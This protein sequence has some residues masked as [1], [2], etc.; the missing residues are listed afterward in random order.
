MAS[1]ERNGPRKRNNPVKKRKK[2]LRNKGFYFYLGGIL[3]RHIHINQAADLITAWNFEEHKRTAYSWSETRRKMRP[4]YRTGAVV[5]MLNRSRI[6][7]ENAI[8]RGDIRK[9]ARP[10]SLDEERRVGRFCWS[11]TDIME[12]RDF[13][14]TQHHGFPRKDGLI[15]PKP[16]PTRIEL[17]AMMEQGTMTYMK[18]SDGEF[19][20]M[21][22][23]IVW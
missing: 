5:E 23:E 15:T 9:P 20:P 11:D 16:I 14:A 18:T 1:E 19:V 7:L 13:F 3:H 2:P 10:Y 12:A 21:F 6:S 17:R 8:L 4:A 22:K